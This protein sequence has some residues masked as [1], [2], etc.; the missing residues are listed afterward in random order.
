MLCLRFYK[1]KHTVIKLSIQ[2][3]TLQLSVIKYSVEINVT[4]TLEIFSVRLKNRS[5]II[6][7][8]HIHREIQRAVTIPDSKYTT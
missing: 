1:R 2:L 7:E 4:K 5:E 8:N 3:I 6:S